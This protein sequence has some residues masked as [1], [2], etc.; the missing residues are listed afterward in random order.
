MAVS[1]FLL[2]SSM[3]QTFVSASSINIKDLAAMSF[4]VESLRLAELWSKY[5]SHHSIQYE[6]T[7]TAA[8]DARYG[9]IS[10][11]SNDISTGLPS[12]TFFMCPILGETWSS[13]SSG[14]VGPIEASGSIPDFFF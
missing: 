8:L 13:G 4:T 12:K 5:L 9:S 3:S 10:I 6:S 14:R 1:K 7:T 11:T 2:V